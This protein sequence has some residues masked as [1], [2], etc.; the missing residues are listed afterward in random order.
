MLL[1]MI[2]YKAN[3]LLHTTLLFGVALLFDNS[4]QKYWSSSVFAPIFL[5]R[6]LLQDQKTYLEPRLCLDCILQTQGRH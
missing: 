3:L 2:A 5:L 1:L 6:H 4:A